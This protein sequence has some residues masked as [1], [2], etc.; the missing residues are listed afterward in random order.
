[1]ATNDLA[2]DPDIWSRVLRD[3]HRRGETHLRFRRDDDWADDEAG[4]PAA[5]Y[6][7]LGPD[8]RG[9]LAALTGRVLD[10]GCGPGRHTLWLQEHG[11]DAVGI[12][13]APG[14]VEVAQ[15]RGCREV[16]VMDALALDFP[17]E[18]FDAAI[19]MGNNLGMA[20]TIEGTLALLRELHRVVRPGGQLRANGRDPLATD[21]PRHL[22]YHEWNRRRGRPPGQ[23]TMRFEYER[24]CGPWFD[25]LLFERERLA[26]L[27]DQTGWR[28][29]KWTGKPPSPTYF[30]VAEH[31]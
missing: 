12:D 2:F 11:L 3:F 13:I 26:D 31:V 15:L 17:D 14:A 30:L 25:W 8:E 7:P 1:M 21:E 9:L 5:Y 23:V 28:P 6:E 20:G 24:Y 10:V 27:L 22:A 16:C 18:S 4:I 19:M 29:L